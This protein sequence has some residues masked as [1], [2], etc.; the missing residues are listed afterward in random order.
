MSTFNGDIFEIPGISVDQF[1]NIHQKCYFL[2]HCHTDHMRGLAL[3]E[4]ET[5][6]YTTAIS[7][8]F[9][10]RKCPHLEKN[11]RVL[12]IGI[13]T[14]VELPESDATFVVTAIAAGHC[15]GACMLLFQIE[16][17]DVLYTG[18]FRISLKNAQNIKLFEE[19]KNHSNAIVYLDSTFMKTTFQRFPS[20][21]ES[22]ETILKIVDTFLKSSR[23]HKVHL[24][25]P[26]RYGYEYLLME[27]ST[28]LN[29]KICILESEVYDQY[30]MISLIESCVTMDQ[31][32]ARII[33]KPTYLN[34]LD[35][36]DENDI[37]LNLTLSAMF[38]TNW[39]GGSF[40]RKM[41]HNSLRVCYAT[42]NSF[43]E[44]RDFL[45]FLMPKKVYLNVL[46]AAPKERLEMLEQLASIQMEYL[47]NEPKAEEENTKEVPK[48]F[49]FKRLRAASSN[50]QV[51]PNSSHDKKLKKL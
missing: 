20:Q 44:I 15:A 40:V 35:Q 7:A 12:E 9:V 28:K 4:T 6:I 23:K 36:R 27:L 19:I 41:A 39:C 48:K 46:P 2:S 16:G 10:R 13:P 49:S 26:A 5:P 3:L 24:K 21:S 43:Q 34:A 29:E 8:L 33:L 51:E 25:V 14:S 32:K 37:I 11:I 42:H 1:E 31:H 18:D 17:C 38:W 45:M 50:K 30:S 47:G 22:V